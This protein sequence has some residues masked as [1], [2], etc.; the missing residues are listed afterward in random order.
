[1]ATNSRTYRTSG[2]RTTGAGRNAWGWNNTTSR[3]TSSQTSRGYS[4]SQFSDVRQQIQCR[5]GS[6]RTLNSQV[7][8]A[9]RV[10]AFSPSVANRWV[11]FVDQGARVFKF[12]G[13]E[14]NRWFGARHDT[15]T[16][17]N[18]AAFKWL[19]WKFGSGIKAVTRG[20]SGTWLVAASS[21]L[22]TGPFRTTGA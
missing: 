20:K 21:K 6:F 17:S 2:R 4:P 22:N 5:L 1:M 15:N 3:N 9:G 11:K 8:G 12:S 19:R 18:A 7:S 14:V 10:T 13:R 16:W